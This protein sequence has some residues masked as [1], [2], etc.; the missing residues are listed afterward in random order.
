MIYKAIQHNVP[1]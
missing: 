1:F